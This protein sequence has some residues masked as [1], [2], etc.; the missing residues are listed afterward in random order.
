MMST[1]ND[2]PWSESELESEEWE[3]AGPSSPSPEAV[4]NEP[5]DIAAAVV[6]DDATMPPDANEADVLEQRT[7]TGLE[8]EDGDEDVG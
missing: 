4:R 5:D 7:E 2:R 1:T 3:A 6:G 8:D